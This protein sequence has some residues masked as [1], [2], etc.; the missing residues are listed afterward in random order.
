MKKISTLTFLSILFMTISLNAQNIT[1]RHSI[2]G[3]WL[4]KLNTGAV[5]L[6]VI[7]NLS[8]AAHDSLVA[9]LDSPDQGAKNI[10]LGLVTLTGETIKISAPALRGEFNGTLKND[11][12]MEGTW[13]QSG[14]TMPLILTRLKAAFTLNRPQEP[15]PPFPYTAEDVT[16]TNSKFNIKLAGTL[17]MPTGNGPFKA[18]IMI[19]G[20]GAQNRNE[21]LMGHKPFLVISDYLTRHGIAVLRYDDRGIGGSQGKYSEATSADLATDAE[22]AFEFLKGNPKI[23][24]AEIGLMGHSEGGLIAPIIASSNHEIGFIVSLAGP[25]VTGQQI[26]IRQQ[27]DIGKLSGA[28]E[29]DIKESSEENKKLYAVLRKEKDNNKAEVK[30]LAIYREILEKKKTSKEDVDK[31]VKTLKQTFGANSYTWFRYFIMTDPAVYWKKVKCPVLALNGEKDLQVAANENL[32]AIE[33]ALKSGGNKSVKI[34]KLPELN[35][36]FQHCKTGLPT[37]YGNIEETFSPE[38][39]KIISD[40]ISGL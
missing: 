22:A 38:A 37:E 11:T 34:V 21:E 15:K 5:Q 35:H 12:T 4:G 26:I 33:K 27:Q 39:L 10:K 23:N 20:S 29:S 32:P 19:T 40:W 24:S 31:G 16:F 3:S 13:M 36:L 6:R 28:K 25:G 2:T 17:T 8:V 1:D 18:V 7:F 9:T 14:N 30:I